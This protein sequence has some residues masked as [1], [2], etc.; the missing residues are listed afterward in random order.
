MLAAISL[1]GLGVGLFYTHPDERRMIEV[2]GRLVESQ[3]VT[4]R[5]FTARETDVLFSLEGQPGR[6]WTPEEKDSKARFD[7]LVPKGSFVRAYINPSEGATPIDGDAVKTYGLWVN[8]RQI[9]TVQGALR[10]D[11]F[12]TRVAMPAIGLIGI[13][14]LV[15]EYRKRRRTVTND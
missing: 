3:E 4:R 15:W 9:I 11:W 1:F 10:R 8:G 13:A 5:I 12:Y 6:F 2:H 7:R 14:A